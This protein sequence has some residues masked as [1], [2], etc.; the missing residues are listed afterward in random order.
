MPSPF[1]PVNCFWE[2]GMIHFFHRSHAKKPES[3]LFS[4]WIGD[5]TDDLHCSDWP[6]CHHPL[7]FVDFSLHFCLRIYTRK[8][9]IKFLQAQFSC[10]FEK[11]LN[12]NFI[13]WSIF[14]LQSKFHRSFEFNLIPLQVTEATN[15]FTLQIIN[16]WMESWPGLT[17][18]QAQF[19]RFSYIL[20]NGYRFHFVSS[21]PPECNFQSETKIEPDLR[22]DLVWL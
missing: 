5:N 12:R 19:E 13:H 16:S 9:I 17:W 10:Q 7:V 1:I 14:H 15:G 6:K 18:D 20:S 8:F 3:G 2:E 11:C 22:L 4:D 21:C